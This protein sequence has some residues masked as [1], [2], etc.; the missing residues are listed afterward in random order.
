[1]QVKFKAF[2]LSYFAR[3]TKAIFDTR[4]AELCDQITGR[5][6]GYDVGNKVSKRRAG[7]V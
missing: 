5:G 3:N 6:V 7:E 4:T 2:A 1:M